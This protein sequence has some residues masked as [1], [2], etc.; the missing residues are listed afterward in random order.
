MELVVA[1]VERG[2]DGLERLKVDVDLLFLPLV[3]DDGP[4]VN[5]QAV[6]GAP[7]VQFQALLGGGD[8]AEDGEPVDAGLNVGRRPVLVRKHFVQL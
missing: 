1:Q 3:R 5:D 7:V 4:A 8:R 6:R 2:V